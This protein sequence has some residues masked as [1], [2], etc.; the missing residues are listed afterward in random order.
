MNILTERVFYTLL[1]ILNARLI[2]KIFKI[3]EIPALRL[4]Y[5]ICDKV[6][7]KCIFKIPEIFICRIT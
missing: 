2:A 4:T 7:K 3:Q 5:K 1:S 6:L